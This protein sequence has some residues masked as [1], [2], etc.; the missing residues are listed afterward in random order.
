[1][2]NELLKEFT[3]DYLLLFND[4]SVSYLKHLQ[5]GFN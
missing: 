2:K 5:N 4:E 1:M 3:H